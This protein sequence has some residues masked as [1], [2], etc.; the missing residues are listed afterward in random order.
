MRLTG[1]LNGTM[2]EKRWARLTDWPLAGA[3]V[4]FLVAYAWSVIGRTTGELNFILQTIM[5]V[6]WLLFIVDYLM[7]LFLAKPRWRWFY[8]HIPDLLIVALPFLRP[9]RLL[10][11][12]ALIGVMQRVAG[13]AL[14]GRVAIYV[15]V[16]GALVVFTAA[17]AELSLEQYAPG[18][19]IR[20]FGDALWWA[21][22]TIST[23]GYGDFVP[24]TDGGRLVAVVLMISGIALLGVVTA[25]LASWF[26][27]RVKDEDSANH[28]ITREQVA[29]LSEQIAALRAELGAR[30]SGDDSDSADAG[31][32]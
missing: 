15:V 2:T 22:V 8:T 19:Q 26:V 30:D 27:E 1:I 25:T 6:V 24:V 11:L 18:A 13:N 31:R 12:I 14:R 28:D 9:L 5:Q 4:V 29:Q 17:L 16:T 21:I 7:R 3:S 23:V 10:R 32:N 20:S